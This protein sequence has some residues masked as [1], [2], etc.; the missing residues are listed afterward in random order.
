MKNINELVVVA[1]LTLFASTAFAARWANLIPVFFPFSTI[2]VSIPF[3]SLC[4]LSAST[5]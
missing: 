4:S 1:V 3:L 5:V 2:A